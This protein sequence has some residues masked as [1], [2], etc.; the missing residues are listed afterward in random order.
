MGSDF[1]H[2]FSEYNW[3]SNIR[4]D[5]KLENIQANFYESISLLGSSTKKNI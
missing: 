3:Y 4:F 5:T 2:D 1:A